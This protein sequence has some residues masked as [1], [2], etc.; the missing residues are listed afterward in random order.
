MGGGVN[1]FFQGYIIGFLLAVISFTIGAQL[2]DAEVIKECYKPTI[3][4]SQSTWNR[5][6]CPFKGE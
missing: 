6:E 3:Q 1:R 2:K 5:I 4:D